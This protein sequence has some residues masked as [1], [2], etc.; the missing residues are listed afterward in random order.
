MSP[1]VATTAQLARVA[2]AAC[3]RQLGGRSLRVPSADSDSERPYARCAPGVQNL[4]ESRVAGSPGPQAQ[5]C[6]TKPSALAV[7]LAVLA[8]LAVLAMALLDAHGGALVTSFKTSAICKQRA[9]DD[10]YATL[11]HRVLLQHVQ[12]V[13]LYNTCRV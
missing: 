11:Q 6:S 9:T 1:R 7:L 10:W 2:V 8:V 12:T 5:K 4:W 3:H 13:R